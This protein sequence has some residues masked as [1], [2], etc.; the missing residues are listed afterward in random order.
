VILYLSTFSSSLQWSWTVCCILVQSSS[1]A[2]TLPMN[3]DRVY[4]FVCRVKHALNI[5]LLCNFK[6]PR[7]F[8]YCLL[9]LYIQIKIIIIITRLVRD[10]LTTFIMSL[11]MKYQVQLNNINNNRLTTTTII[12]II[13]R[14]STQHL[15][16]LAKSLWNACTRLNSFIAVLLCNLGRWLFADSGKGSVGA[17]LFKCLPL[18][19]FCVPITF[20]FTK[21]LLPPMISR[22]AQDSDQEQVL[23]I[24]F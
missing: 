6:V 1:D 18:C 12:I 3:A 24:C 21:R 22:T 15:N 20:W 10:F 5:V 9:R 4:Y 7:N 14:Q 17:F 2:C 19:I 13:I 8:T 23:A 11:G 16:L